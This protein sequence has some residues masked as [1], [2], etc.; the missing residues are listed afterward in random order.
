MSE[1][2]EQSIKNI[3]ISLAVELVL[4]EFAE[5][6]WECT[7]PSGDVKVFTK[8]KTSSLFWF[9]E[10]NLPSYVRLN[11]QSWTKER[12]AV[13]SFEWQRAGLVP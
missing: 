9:Q 4:S 11:I 2:R 8:R 1:E 7:G 10:R 13:P 3:S 12:R 6:V 5:S